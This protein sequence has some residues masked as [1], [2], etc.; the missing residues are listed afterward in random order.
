M[1]KLIDKLKKFYASICPKCQ[2]KGVFDAEKKSYFPGE[3]DKKYFTCTSCKHKWIAHF[4]NISVCTLIEIF[5]VQDYQAKTKGLFSCPKC[6]NDHIKM[7]GQT[8]VN[9][10]QFS[11]VCKKCKYKWGK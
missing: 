11:Y 6:N 9:N 10:P 4:E 7:Y 1:S 5:E 2:K 8:G 3:T